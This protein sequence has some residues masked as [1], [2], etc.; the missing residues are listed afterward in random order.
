[1]IIW[2]EDASGVWA[3]YTRF[4]DIG[5][6][7]GGSIGGNLLGFT[8]GCV[9]GDGLA[10]LG[11]GYGGS[12][13]L[14]RKGAESDAERWQPHSYLTGHF[15][16]VSDLAW[17]SDGGYFVTVSSDQTTRLFAPV[18]STGASRRCWKEL[19]RPQVHGFDLNAVAISPLP[20]HTIYSA[21]DEKIIRA[22]DATSG[23]L[24]GLERLSGLSYGGDEATAANRVDHAFIP[25]LG[26]S[27]KPSEQMT[28]AEKSELQARNVSSLTW[29]TPPLESQLS[30]HTIW[31]ESRKLYGHTNDVI[32]IALSS[33]GRLL[34]SAC[35]S[36]N[37]QTAGII[38]WD[39]SSM[40]AVQTLYAH[41]ST[42]AC[43]RFSSDDTFL[44][45]SGKD[46]ILCA[47]A[48][49]KASERLFKVAAATR[50]AHRRIVWDCSWSD[51]H[52]LF[53]SSRDGSFK[54]WT[55]DRKCDDIYNSFS[56]ICTHTPFCEVAVTSID[57]ICT[58]QGRTL[59]VLGSEL[60]DIHIAEV[61]RRG[62][63]FVV[64]LL[65]RVDDILAHGSAVKRARWC[66]GARG[67]AGA[68]LLATCGAD[69]T[70]RVFKIS[71]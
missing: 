66:K 47:Y 36:R 70:T 3:P 19:S 62:A 44:A 63:E 60:G 16:C 55:I 8:C 53:T 5:G 10:V 69:T 28:A 23:V 43:L 45:S 65:L 33:S 15:G 29:V 17:A 21:G 9:S 31:P 22:F 49:D 14:W 37:S 64:A 26:L 41:E 30:D 20:A 50:N 4:G 67:S 32:C 42:V 40:A 34:A 13:H 54:L 7:L 35:K 46:R 68:A 48:F 59:L 11:V 56:C 57:A 61:T 12:F 1:M 25:E 18:L 51:D 6:N 2:R 39:T 58:A 71:F 38:I 52:V 27:N 24:L